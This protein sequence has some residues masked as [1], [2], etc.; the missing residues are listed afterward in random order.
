MNYECRD[1]FEKLGF[2]EGNLGEPNDF[3]LERA[4]V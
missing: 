1:Y 3:V 4:F 2:I